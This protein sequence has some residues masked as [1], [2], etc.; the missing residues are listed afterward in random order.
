MCVVAF[1]AYWLTD[2][3]NSQ[4]A[5]W[6]E[7]EKTLTTANANEIKLLWKVKLDKEVREK[8]A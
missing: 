2:G 3:K 4:R 1:A 6:Q 7:D 8:P 5:N